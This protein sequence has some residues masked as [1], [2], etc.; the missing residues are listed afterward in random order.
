LRIVWKLKRLKEHTKAW[1]KDK[2]ASE[3]TNLLKLES[4][5][6][7]LLLKSTSAA[8]SLEDSATLKALERS[9]DSFC[10]KKKNVGGFAAVRP[11]SNGETL[12]QIIFT[13]WPVTIETKN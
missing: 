2:K 10:G 5:I 9:R 13:E 7:K 6:T 4:E 3:E 1:S 11:G 8:L 12:I